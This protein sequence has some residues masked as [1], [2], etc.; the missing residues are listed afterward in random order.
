MN[1]G[2]NR[3]TYAHPQAVMVKNISPI[4]FPPLLHGNKTITTKLFYFILQRSYLKVIP[5]YGKT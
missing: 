4:A 2:R 3:N 1:E 5:H